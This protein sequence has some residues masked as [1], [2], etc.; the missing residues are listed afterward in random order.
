VAKPEPSQYAFHLKFRGWFEVNLTQKAL[1]TSLSA[2][3]R[4]WEFTLGWISKN[5]FQFYATL[6]FLAVWLAL[7]ARKQ[8]DIR[9]MKKE[10]DQT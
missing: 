9:R 1:S 3:E 6:I 8:T 2:A 10:L 4:W 7:N 5:P